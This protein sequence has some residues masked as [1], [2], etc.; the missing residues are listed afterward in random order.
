MDSQGA[1]RCMSK[2]Y[3]PVFVLQNLVQ[4]ICAIERIRP[5]SIEFEK[6]P[7]KLSPADA[8]SRNRPI[9]TELPSTLGRQ[10]IPLDATG[11]W[12]EY[13]TSDSGES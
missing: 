8:P 6:I 1:L 3:S 9:D 5:L 7:S 12:C 2:R 10:Q 13:D 11:E 4:R